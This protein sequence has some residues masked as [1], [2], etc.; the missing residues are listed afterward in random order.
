MVISGGSPSQ[1]CGRGSG[2][3][4]VWS[5]SSSESSG[6]LLTDSVAEAGSMSSLRVL[7]RVGEGSR[8]VKE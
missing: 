8:R 3:N 5:P 2:I 4:G 1:P 6:E 7:L